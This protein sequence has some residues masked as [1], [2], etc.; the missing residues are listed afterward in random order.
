MKHLGLAYIQF[1]QNSV[2]FHAGHLAS[3]D[4]P[5]KLQVRAEATFVL[6]LSGVQLLLQLPATELQVTRGSA[7]RDRTDNGSSSEGAM[8]HPDTRWRS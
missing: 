8:H 4:F 6:Q 1:S 2:G 5:M 7:G 3:S